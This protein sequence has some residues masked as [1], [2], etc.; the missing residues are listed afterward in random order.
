MCALGPQWLSGLKCVLMDHNA[1]Y[2]PGLNPTTADPS[3]KQF[4][5]SLFKGWGLLLASH[6]FFHLTTDQFN[7]NEGFLTGA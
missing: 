4:V 6:F 5:G 7:I 2:N 3:V 1:S